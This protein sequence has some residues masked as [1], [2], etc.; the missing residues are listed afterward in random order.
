MNQPELT[1]PDTTPRRFSDELSALVR[2]GAPM[3][4]TQFF[5][6]AMGF[7]DTA[8]AGRYDSAHL[9]GVALGGSILWPV[10]MLT[11][12]FTMAITPI[13]AQLRGSGALADAGAQVRQGLWL[14]I[15]ASVFC[16]LIVTNAAPVF[17]FVKV[18][19]PRHWW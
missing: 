14:G 9:A 8:M 16:V 2:L 4:A 15:F 6:M 19:P 13:V 18:D 11:T 5:I 17:A 1:S 3:V 12:G 10:F 7:I